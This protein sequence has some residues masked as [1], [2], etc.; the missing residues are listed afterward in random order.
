MKLFYIALAFL[1]ACGFVK[2]WWA[3]KESE[4][5]KNSRTSLSEIEQIDYLEN[6]Y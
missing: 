1:F 6:N 4:I 2:G 5:K 3:A